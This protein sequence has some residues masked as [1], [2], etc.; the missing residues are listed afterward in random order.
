M[1]AF[2][3]FLG[4]V[5]ADPSPS[6]RAWTMLREGITDQSAGRRTKAVHSLRLIKD[7]R[8]QSMAEEALSDA[9]KG[10]R[11]EAAAVLGFMN[12]GAARPRLH[13]CLDDKELQVVLA[14][15]NSLYL[16]KDPVAFDVYYALL[17]EQ[18]KSS[19]GLLQSQLDALHDRKQV[20][21]LALE[22]GMGFVPYGGVGLQAVK[23]VTTDDASPVRALAAER[24][25]TDPDPQSEK[26]LTDYLADKKVVVREA[27]VAAIAKRG[28]PRLAKAVMPLLDDDNESVRFDAAATVVCLSE[29][30]TV[31]QSKKQTK[32][33]K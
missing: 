4:A 31:R 10:V 32:T 9:D 26:A 6:Q 11:A 7:R 29:P 20:E 22:A 23:V 19:Q 5:L 18:R 21:K 2:F 17:T 12:D 3:L 14:C 15:A 24:L 25:A 16:L 1:V 27:V 8:A 13:A 33:P 28:D 30:R